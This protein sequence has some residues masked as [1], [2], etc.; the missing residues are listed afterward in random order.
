[1][2]FVCEYDVFFVERLNCIGKQTSS[3]QKCTKKFGELANGTRVDFVDEYC[4]LG[5]NTAME[6]VK[7]FAQ[8]MVAIFQ[9]MYLK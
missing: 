7:H 8:A 6:C 3:I 1:M 9:L 4:R 2:A 5:K